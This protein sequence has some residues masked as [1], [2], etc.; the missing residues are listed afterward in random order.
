MDE[1]NEVGSAWSITGNIIDYPIH[2]V[3][4][5]FIWRV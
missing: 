1:K 2:S 3:A 4:R 5:I